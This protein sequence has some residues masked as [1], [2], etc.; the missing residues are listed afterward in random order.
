MSWVGNVQY[1]HDRQV[2]KA[3]T[4]REPVFVKSESV[5]IH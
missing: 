3:L 5:D 1:S 2:M 4:V